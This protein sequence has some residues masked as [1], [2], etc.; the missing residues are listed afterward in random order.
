[1]EAELVTRVT[2]CSDGRS[3]RGSQGRWPRDD[4]STCSR[5]ST[6]AFLDKLIVPRWEYGETERSGM[7][8]VRTIGASSGGD[9]S[10]IHRRRLVTSAVASASNAPRTTAGSV[11]TASSSS[12]RSGLRRHGPCERSRGFNA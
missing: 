9:V 5:D 11:R 8:R 12:R 2:V 1:M 3:M 6:A 4:L 10:N 7:T